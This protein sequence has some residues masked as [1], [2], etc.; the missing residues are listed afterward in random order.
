MPPASRNL[1][2]NPIE[3]LS[4]GV[5]VRDHQTKAEKAHSAALQQSLQCRSSLSSRTSG[6]LG[7]SLAKLE[8]CYAAHLSPKAEHSKSSVLWQ[9]FAAGLS[10]ARVFAAGCSWHSVC[11][12]VFATVPRRTDEAHMW[13]AD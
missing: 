13:R 1:S 2:L 3:G 12:W 6:H 5:D 4:I 10:L 8:A 9:N 11:N 7:F